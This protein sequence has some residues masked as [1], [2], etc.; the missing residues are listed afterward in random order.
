MTCD[1]SPAAALTN[2][3]QQ[4]NVVLPPTPAPETPEEEPDPATD[5]GPSAPPEVEEQGRSEPD[6]PPPP[7]RDPSGDEEKSAQRK[8]RGR[9]SDRQQETGRG[10]ADGHVSA[11]GPGGDLTLWQAD[12]NVEN[13]FKP[14]TTRGQRSVRRSLRNRSSA[15]GEGAG[16]AWLPQTP[17][18]DAQEGRRRTCRPDQDPGRAG[19]RRCT[20]QKHTS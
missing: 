11:G 6:T 4:L 7:P 1:S 14:V 13:V 19:E 10:A 8:R 17:P 18:T 9:R 16:L 20:R 3:I 12:F 15:G 2:E 5:E